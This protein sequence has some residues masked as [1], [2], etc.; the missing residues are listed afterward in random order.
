MQTKKKLA[1]IIVVY[2]K[3]LSESKTLSSLKAFQESLKDV[4]LVI[5]NNGPKYLTADDAKYIE[6]IDVPNNI[7]QS[8][9]NRG[10]A[11]I[12]NFFIREFHA[13]T[14]AF[15]D[16][17]T[18]LNS[19]YLSQ[20]KNL[21]PIEIGVPLIKFESVIESPT[22]N[23]KKIGLNYDF[24]KDDQIYAVTS[25]LIIGREIL[26][27]IK[28]VKYT[29][30]DEAFKLYGVDTS[31]FRTFNTLLIS[32]KIKII[33]ELNHSLSRLS[34]TDK[35]DE[36]RIKE[37]ANA[38]AILSKRYDVLSLQSKK[39]IRIIL[40]GLKKICRLQAPKYEWLY[41]KAYFRGRHYRS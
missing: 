11:E 3:S 2:N 8:I 22:V 1:M 24:K 37:R 18:A 33:G 35:N 17:D 27:T 30:F 31:F 25:G 10:L 39:L 19:N 6:T 16:D 9:E 5:W 13:E 29:Y 32:D 20:I 14:Y 40:G 34:D 38:E 28:Q 36:F 7:Y 23:G 4:N 41:V 15:L 21:S 12:Y 26:E